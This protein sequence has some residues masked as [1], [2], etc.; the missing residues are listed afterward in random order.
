MADETVST[1]RGALAGELVWVTA[2]GQVG[3]VAV[4]PL[5]RNGMPCVALPYASAAAVETLRSATRAAFV[6]S[7]GRSST[8]TGAVITGPVRVFDDLDGAT[9]G[10]DLLPGELVKHPPSRV[11]VDSTLLRRENWWWIP[12]IIVLLTAV[13][14]TYELPR[15][16]DPALEGVLAYDDGRRLRVDVVTAADGEWGTP[17]LGLH[18]HGGAQLRGSGEPAVIIGHDYSMPDFERWETWTIRGVL[19]GKELLVADRAGEPGALLRPLGL[20][21]RIRRQRTLE[22]A[23]R[24]GIEAAER[25]QRRA[26]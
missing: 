25:A 14:G 9:F 4:V 22:R 7:D 6:V 15:R 16:T 26:R 8:R 21:D 10:T 17:R 20:R 18:T 19:R 5:E 23:C 3:G 11:L 2:T 12:R 1:W 13:D 24:E